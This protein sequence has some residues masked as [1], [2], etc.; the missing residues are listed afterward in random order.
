MAVTITAADVQGYGITGA[1]AMI[2]GYIALVAQADTCLDKNKVPDET[3]R[4]LKI[5]AVAHLMTLAQ[6]GQIRSQSAPSGASR[7][8]ATPTGQGIEL[9]NWGSMLKTL[10]RY[11]CITSL[12]EN[13]KERPMVMSVGP[14]RRRSC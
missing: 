5:N 9:T 11:G 12:L 3:Q 10:D 8:F 4:L 2:D 6:G 14:G 13:D 1:D 7:S